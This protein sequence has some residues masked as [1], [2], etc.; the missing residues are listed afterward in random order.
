M[1]NYTKLMAVEST[2]DAIKIASRYETNNVYFIKT[3]DMEEW[4]K[5]PSYFITKSFGDRLSNLFIN[6]LYKDGDPDLEQ[7]K[8]L[9][10]IKSALFLK[11]LKKDKY[12]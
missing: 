2:Y 7:E 1:P 6:F 11:E 12:D 5:N 10:E 9:S 3:S 8:L 4:S